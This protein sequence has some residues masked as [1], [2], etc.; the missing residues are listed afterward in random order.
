MSVCVV[1]EALVNV[2]VERD[3]ERI[4]VASLRIWVQKQSKGKESYDKRRRAGYRCFIVS[5]YSLSRDNG[6]G[7]Q[8]TG[9]GPGA[10]LA[11]L[12]VSGFASSSS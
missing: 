4:E 2:S 8:T 7:D 12:R 10:L 6:N 11:R 1:S 3:D 5:D 9:E